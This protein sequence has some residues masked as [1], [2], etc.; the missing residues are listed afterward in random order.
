MFSSKKIFNTIKSNCYIAIAVILVSSCSRPIKCLVKKCES[1]TQ[2]VPDSTDNGATAN[3]PATPSPTAPGAADAITQEL[4]NM[5]DRETLLLMIDAIDQKLT[6]IIG[7]TLAKLEAHGLTLQKARQEIDEKRQL[8][9]Q[10]TATLAITRKAEYE[11]T[12]STLEAT[13]QQIST[14]KFQIIAGIEAI[15]SAILDPLTPEGVKT[16]IEFDQK[17]GDLDLARDRSDKASIEKIRGELKQFSNALLVADKMLLNNLIDQLA[18]LSASLI[19]ANAPIQ[20]AGYL[21][22]MLGLEDKIN[23]LTTVEKPEVIAQYQSKID[24]VKK[25]M[26]AP[27]S[28]L[29]PWQVEGI[30]KIETGYQTALQTAA[31][32]DKYIAFLDS[33]GQLLAR[34]Y[35]HSKVKFR[36]ISMTLKN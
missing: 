20:I 27:L 2:D 6:N 29:A 17:M 23:A 8:E 30:S 11:K 13:N 22:Q 9:R 33:T 24:T 16:Q 25:A 10:K 4:K 35:L 19:D 1:T 21:R 7:V 3:T 32:L 18:N 5:K 28:T 12:I 36:T 31:V 26:Q 14:Q 34:R 15:E